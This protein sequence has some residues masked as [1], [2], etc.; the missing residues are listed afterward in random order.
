LLALGCALAVFACA[1][2]PKPEQFGRGVL[3]GRV[4]LAAE[5]P[6]PEYAASDLYRVP[7]HSDSGAAPAACAEANERARRPVALT[8]DGLLS[9]I[10]VA[11]SDFTHARS[12]R[13]AR[14][15]HHRVAIRDCQL[16]PT[17]I[18]ARDG[19]WLEIENQDDYPFSPL[20]GPAFR[21]EPLGKGR[22]LKIPIAGGR[23]DS[24]LC[25]PHAPCG[26]ADIVSFR[27]PVFAVTDATG[28]FRI[29]NF[30]DSELVRVTAW[31][32]LFEAS[33]NFTWVEPGHTETLEL[34][35][36]PKERFLPAGTAPTTAAR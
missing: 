8:D 10:V 7:M 27:H 12:G 21:P 18:A 11:A 28:H 30:P 17:V 23:V 33:E 25:T 35:I 3:I 16:Q 36:K 24:L 14:T 6:L 22:V 20:L 34:V 26:R 32:P 9:G 31:H 2:K 19:D 1:G 4:R 15:V 5:A 13:R 29:P